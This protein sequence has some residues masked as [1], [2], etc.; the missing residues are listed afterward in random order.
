[1]NILEDDFNTFVGIQNENKLAHE[2]IK[3][4][5]ENIRNVI[6]RYKTN[7]NTLSIGIEKRAED[8][9]SNESETIELKGKISFSKTVLDQINSI[10]LVMI[11]EEKGINDNLKV[12]KDEA[13]NFENQLNN[14][15][16]DRQ[17]ASDKVYSYEIKEN[18][19]KLRVE[20]LIQHIKHLMILNHIILMKL[21]SK[22]RN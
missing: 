7:Q 21:L 16:H 6:N 20:N 10:R 12:I 4:Q 11:E 1:L 3:G 18:E 15:R 22:F 2:R 9:I 19:T 13:A 14:L 5:I 8:L 17:D